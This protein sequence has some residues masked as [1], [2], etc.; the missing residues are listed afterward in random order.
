MGVFRAQP[1]LPGIDLIPAIVLHPEISEFDAMRLRG[2]TD[3]RHTRSKDRGNEQVGQAARTKI[4]SR[5]EALSKCA[6]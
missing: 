5:T 3:S 6:E 2:A 4:L 1:S